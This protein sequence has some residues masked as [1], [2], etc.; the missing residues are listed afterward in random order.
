MH[1]CHEVYK[2]YACAMNYSK[3]EHVLVV[4]PQ[5]LHSYAYLTVAYGTQVLNYCLLQCSAPRVSCEPVT[6]QASCWPT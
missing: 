3:I 2:H 5:V 6:L 1:G 4:I